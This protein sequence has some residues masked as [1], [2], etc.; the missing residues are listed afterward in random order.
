LAF[1]R[2]VMGA[3]GPLNQT[4]L[5]LFDG[6]RSHGWVDGRNLITEYRFSQPPDRLPA[7]R[8]SR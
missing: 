2:R 8:H 6:L 4:E 1:L 7:S 3:G 5:A